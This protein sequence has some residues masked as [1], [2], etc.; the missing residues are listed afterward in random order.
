MDRIKAASDI[1]KKLNSFMSGKITD[2]DFIKRS[3]YVF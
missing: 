2:Y 1:I 3:L